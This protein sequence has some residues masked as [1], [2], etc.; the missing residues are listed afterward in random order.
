MALASLYNQNVSI[1]NVL[2]SKSNVTLAQWLRLKILH[3]FTWKSLSGDRRF[4]A[5]ARK[6]NVKFDKDGLTQTKKLLFFCIVIFT[7]INVIRK[8]IKYS[9]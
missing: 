8:V 6:C 2:A 5:H 1:L 4:Y 9:K 7:D 3:F